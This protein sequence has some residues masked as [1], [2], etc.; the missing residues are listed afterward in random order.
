MRT[1]L[2]STELLGAI[3]VDDVGVCAIKLLSDSSLSE[4]TLANDAFRSHVLRKMNDLEERSMILVPVPPFVDREELGATLKKVQ[5]S[6]FYWRFYDDL[7]SE[8]SITYRRALP[9]LW[10]NANRARL[11]IG[12]RC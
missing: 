7:E 3:L 5:P 4:K 8:D 2:S 11:L 1:L 6:T 10:G 12:R 9:D